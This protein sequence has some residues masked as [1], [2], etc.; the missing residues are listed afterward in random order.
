[1]MSTLDPD[2]KQHQHALQLTMWAFIRWMKSD[3]HNESHYWEY[4]KDMKFFLDSHVLQLQGHEPKDVVKMIKPTI[5]DPECKFL[6]PTE[7]TKES[8]SDEGMPQEFDTPSEADI[9]AKFPKEML[10]PEVRTNIANIIEHMEA[11]HSEAAK[12]MKCMQEFFPTIPVGAFHLILQAMVQ[13]HIMNQHWWLCHIKSGEQEHPHTASLVDMVPD[14]SKSQN[15]PVPVWTLAAILHF[16]VKNEAGM[17]VSIVQTAKLFGSQEKL[18][19]QALKGVCYES[20]TQKCRHLDAAHDKEEE[21]SFSE[22]EDDDDDDEDE[23]AVEKI[24]PLKKCKK[25]GRSLDESEACDTEVAFQFSS[26]PFTPTSS[27]SY[28][29]FYPNFPLQVSIYILAHPVKILKSHMKFKI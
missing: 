27:L 7:S 10:T 28:S 1:M 26:R 14:G 9:M 8:D 5:H 25:W 29:K 22:T 6:H 21:S 19:H 12:S 3:D 24:K 13:P 2:A 17:K 23:G 11:S 16:Q 15:L 18:F 4:I 20:G